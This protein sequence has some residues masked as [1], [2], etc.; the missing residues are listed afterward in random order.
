MIA[1]PLISKTRLEALCDGI[2]AVALTLLALDLKLPALADSTGPALHAALAA[3]LVKALVWVLSF[4]VAA[5]FWLAQNRVLRHYA[6]LDGRALAIELAQLALITLLPFSTALVGEYGNLVAA[7]LIYSAHLACLATL[8]VLRI[9]RLLRRPELR[10]PGTADATLRWQ[11]R[12]AAVLLVCT[13]VA[14][15]LARVVPGWNMLAML[16]TL[17]R[18]TLRQPADPASAA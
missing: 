4:W 6:R 14:V 13:L 18:R 3:L 5:L 9:V 11:L 17:L 10:E 7:A 1:A 12:R 15:A 8:S 16:G 2:Y